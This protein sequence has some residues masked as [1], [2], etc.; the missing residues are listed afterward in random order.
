MKPA[1]AF[2]AVCA[3]GAALIFISEN[4]CGA[5]DGY[6]WTVQFGIGV[7]ISSL[8]WKLLILSLGI[9]VFLVLKRRISAL[10]GGRG[11]IIYFAVLPLIAF[12]HQFWLIPQNVMDKNVVGAICAKSCAEGPFSHSV[13]LDL[14][15]YD[16]LRDQ[17]ILLPK[18]P[19]TADSICVH[20]YPDGF[21]PDYSLTVDFRCGVGEAIDTAGGR[22]S[23]RS[24]DRITN[25]MTVSYVDRET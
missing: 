25:R 5:V 10:V 13:G 24:I 21:L 2:F 16:H 7:I 6:Y 3:F 9:A 17:L 18:L 11:T 19:S 15:E 23:I 1:F 14:R 20:Y 12:H 4:S 8:L 22:W